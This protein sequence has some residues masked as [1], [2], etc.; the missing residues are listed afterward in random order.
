MSDNWILIF[1]FVHIK[2]TC[3]YNGYN[4]IWNGYITNLQT[5]TDI[6]THP[7]TESIVLEIS[8]IIQLCLSN[9]INLIAVF[10]FDWLSG[11][12][13]TEKQIII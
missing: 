9:Q 3:K 8:I 13:Y 5:H 11:F 4:I 7:H 2:F 6:N 10:V 12:I 1:F